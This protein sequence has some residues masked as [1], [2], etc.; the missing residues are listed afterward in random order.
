MRPTEAREARYQSGAFAAAAPLVPAEPKPGGLLRA[1]AGAVGRWLRAVGVT[2]VIVYAVGWVALSAGLPL[3]TRVTWM[4]PS[5]ENTLAKRYAADAM[6]PYALPRDAA[7][8]PLDAGIALSS[9]GTAPKG[10]GAGFTY[11]TLD[12]R[13]D[14]PWRHMEFADAL[15]PGARRS[16]YNGPDPMSIVAAAARG[17]TPAQRAALRPYGTAE[18]WATFD[19]VVR[20]PQVDIVAGR[21]VLPFGPEARASW[22]P[23][24]KFTESKELAYAG[25]ARA[26][27]LLSEGRR[28]E[29]EAALR[30]VISFG[31]VF[32]DNG[33]TLIEELIGDVIVGIGRAGLRD[34]YAATGDAR[35]A[36]LDAAV[37]EAQRLSQAGSPAPWPRGPFADSRAGML[38]MSTRPGRLT[39]PERVETLYA[40]TSTTCG[41][42]RDL[43]LG[44][45]PGVRAAFEAVR[46]DY[47]GLPGQ[48]AVVD[49][50][51]RQP[52]DGLSRQ[53][54]S[55]GP[56][57]QFVDA[58]S[59]A[60][61][62]PRIAS[63]FAGNRLSSIY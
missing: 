57:G 41:S 34:L 19:R 16:P 56:G 59:R 29:A 30:G 10:A 17:L 24:T 21:F 61:F 2:M 4:A 58:I 31:F 27:W 13:P 12:H 15:F 43:V 36:A 28:T 26:A 11:R 62:N 32:V 37:T 49:L 14:V 53:Q 44:E 51:E 6:R 33:T 25:V 7:I 5:I 1:A 54:A 48:R 9:M 46:R 20:A 50:I 35:L 55:S 42:T 63:C 8:T 39:L 60:Y 22:M 3:V 47:A 40:V 52:L 45:S 38:E 23:I 18:V